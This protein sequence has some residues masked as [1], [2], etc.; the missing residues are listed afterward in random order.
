MKK[1]SDE[2]VI[3]ALLTTR[4]YEECANVLGCT[5]QTVYRKMQNP[6]FLDKYRQKQCDKFEMTYNS[7]QCATDDA[8]TYLHSVINSPSESTSCR[9]NA[10]RCILDYQ[11]KSNEQLT[12]LREL[13]EV[14]Q[15]LEKLKC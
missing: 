3:N 15:Q 8:I 13:A 1:L 2:A 14:K 5:V 4:N 7:I 10:C 11:L 6:Q 9:I 12:I